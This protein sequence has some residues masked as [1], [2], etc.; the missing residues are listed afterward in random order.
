MNLFDLPQRPLSEELTEILAQDRKTR[1]ERIVS[2]GQTTDWYDQTETEFVAVLQGEGDLEYEDGAIK[3]LKAGD[4]LVIPP[5]QRHRV[6]RTSTNPPC[7]WLC[8][9]WT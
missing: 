7:V 2:T 9:F 1:V 8:V 3:K 4:W 5:H 6:C